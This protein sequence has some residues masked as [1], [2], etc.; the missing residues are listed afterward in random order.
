MSTTTFKII[1]NIQYCL[2]NFPYIICCKGNSLGGPFTLVGFY[3]YRHGDC[4][5]LE[6]SCYDIVHK[7]LLEHPEKRVT[8]DGCC[9]DWPPLITY[10]S[11]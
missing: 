11:L 2:K 7:Y 6:D 8:F 9:E 4:I 1:S 3:T 10:S 5:R